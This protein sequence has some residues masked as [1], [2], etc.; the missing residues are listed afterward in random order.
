METG[1]RVPAPTDQPLRLEPFPT[2]EDPS[3]PGPKLH[4]ARARRRGGG[5]CEFAFHSR[6]WESDQKPLF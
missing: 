6:Q 3:H 2:S 4:V 5:L 1:A